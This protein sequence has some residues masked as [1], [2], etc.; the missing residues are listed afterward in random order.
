MLNTE[1]VLLSLTEFAE[2]LVCMQ[3]VK[4][5]ANQREEELYAVSRCGQFEREAD[6]AVGK[7][8]FSVGS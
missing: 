5:R 8:S 6:E 4:F 7:D 3:G 2:Y 1:V